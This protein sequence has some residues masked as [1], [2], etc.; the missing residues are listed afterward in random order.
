MPGRSDLIDRIVDGRINADQDLSAPARRKYSLSSLEDLPPKRQESPVPV[1]PRR[2][3]ESPS[4]RP[5]SEGQKLKRSDTWNSASGR[6]SARPAAVPKPQMPGATASG[7]RRGSEKPQE[8]PVEETSKLIAEVQTMKAALRQEED[9]LHQ[10]RKALNKDSSP[11]PTET[12]FSG[13]GS[14]QEEVLQLPNAVPEKD[15]APS[16]TESISTGPVKAKK[17]G[18]ILPSWMRNLIDK[19]NQLMRPA[20]ADYF[21][22]KQ[23]LTTADSVDGSAG[24]QIQSQARRASLVRRNSRAI[25]APGLKKSRTAGNLEALEHSVSLPNLQTGK[26]K[27]RRHSTLAPGRNP[28]PLDGMAQGAVQFGGHSHD[29]WPF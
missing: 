17:K 6:N 13:P 4:T 24:L 16:P 21:P 7:S 10:L 14:P 28:A 8:K 11:S 9:Q 3:A 22:E 26:E 15:S 12:A 27:A 2:R 1:R 29:S 25:T 18:G 20:A 23:R 5:R 19:A